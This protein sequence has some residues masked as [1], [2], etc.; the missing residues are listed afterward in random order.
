MWPHA[1]D[2]ASPWLFEPLHFCEDLDHL[3]WQDVI[4]APHFLPG[5]KGVP[6]GAH[7]V[8]LLGT[9]KPVM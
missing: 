7:L 6:K 2:P 4:W 1:N 8:R 5:H 9:P 3:K